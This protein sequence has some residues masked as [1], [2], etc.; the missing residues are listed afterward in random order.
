MGAAVTAVT[1]VTAAASA[2]E[3]SML[4]GELKAAQL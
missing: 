4:R 1:A 2:A 3:G